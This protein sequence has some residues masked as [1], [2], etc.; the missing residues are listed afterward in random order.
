MKGIIF[1][2]S[3]KVQGI[4]KVY[5]GLRDCGGYAPVPAFIRFVQALF[6]RVFRR[7]EYN[8]MMSYDY[9]YF[10]HPE[11]YQTLFTGKENAALLPLVNDQAKLYLLRQKH[12]LPDRLGGLG[13]RFLL[14]RCH[15]PEEVKTFFKKDGGYIL[16]PDEGATSF[17]I[18]FLYAENETLYHWNPA[19]GTRRPC[20]DFLALYKSWQTKNM[21]IEEYVKQHAQLDTIFSGCVNTIYFHTVLLPDGHAELVDTPLMS[22]GCGKSSFVNS[23]NRLTVR[24]RSDGTLVP[25]GF[26]LKKNAY[27][28][29]QIEKVFQ[30]PDTGVS[31]DGFEIPYWEDAKKLA[32]A[33]AE[34]LP[35][36]TYIKWDIAISETGPVILEGNGLPGSFQA[37]QIIS[38]AARGKGVKVEFSEFLRAIAFS[39]DLTP[40]KIQAVNQEISRFPSGC[41]PEDCDAVIVLG[42]TKCTSRIAAAFDAFGDRARYILCGGTASEHFKNPLKPE[43]GKLTE[44]DYMRQY[45]V[46]RGVAPER[47]LTDNTSFNTQENLAHAAKLLSQSGSKKAAIVSAWFHGRRVFHLAAQMNDLGFS[48]DCLCFIP[49]YGG[50]TRPDNWFQSLYGIKAIYHEAQYSF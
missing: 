6:F 31:L 15:S 34:K 7:E 9:I 46:E 50:Q 28:R 36:L 45:L 18:S 27:D 24:V 8:E 25:Y 17:G 49:A 26:F 3:S 42:S 47:I 5:C 16:K 22:C 13:R 29:T 10:K 11:V 39:K 14:V 40:E 19:E 21:L 43:E 37:W 41:A 48:E 35:E 23:E 12:L 33:S 2:V 38:L 1:K 30:H 4:T 44:A 32:I 20:G